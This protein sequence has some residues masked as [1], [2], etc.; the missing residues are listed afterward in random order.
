MTG[1]EVLQRLRR[2]ASEK[3]DGELVVA[4]LDLQLHVRF[5]SGRIAWAS[6]V[7]GRGVFVDELARHAK[8]DPHALR[9]LATTCRRRG[10]P[11]GETVLSLGL[12]SADV[13]RASLARQ[14]R[15]VLAM[16]HDR[17]GL[18]VAFVEASARRLDPTLTF[19][20]DELLATTSSDETTLCTLLSKV[21]EAQEIVIVREGEE[22]AT[23][24]ARR[25]GPAERRPPGH[26]EEGTELAALH[27]GTSAHVVLRL[28]LATT[29]EAWLRLATPTRLGS[30]LARLSPSSASANDSVPST[31]T[32]WREIGEANERV[33]RTLKGLRERAP[34]VRSVH[35]HTLAE[36]Y[37]Q[38]ALADAEAVFQ[39]Q[40]RWSHWLGLDVSDDPALLQRHVPTLVVVTQDL[41]HVAML[42][43]DQSLGVLW[44][45]F[46]RHTLPELAWALAEAGVRELSAA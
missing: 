25:A 32:E 22:S 43:P 7:P 17:E 31:P 1:L 19:D 40:R 24:R 8:V 38:H 44:W 46:D 36:S 21:P 12:T 2:L 34:G 20:L 26:L 39:R 45:C 5:Q 23:W 15:H 16:L 6:S 18:E 9:E 33:R 3:A 41:L 35:L 4:G 14:V 30:V 28:G 27:Q 29:H 42:L 37:A 11:L 13:V 10:L